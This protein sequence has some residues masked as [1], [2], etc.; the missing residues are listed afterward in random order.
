M[1]KL[2]RVL[3]VLIAIL[4]IA[5]MGFSGVVSFTGPNW[6]AEMANL[7]GYT[8][9]TIPGEKPTYQVVRLSDSQNVGSPV[10]VRA[11]ALAI[12]IKD[13]AEQAQVELDVLKNGQPN[14]IEILNVRAQSIR[15]KQY[16]DADALRRYDEDLD[17][18]L[19]GIRAELATVKDEQNRLL[20]EV[21]KVE[22]RTKSRREDVYRLDFQHRLVLAQI[23]ES[24][25]NIAAL[26]EQIILL[27]D[28]LDKALRRENQLHDQGVPPA[29]VAVT[30]T[31]VQ[32]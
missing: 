18:R 25:Q 19:E 8:F 29:P 12:A 11:E 30:S 20:A 21:D 4:S 22:R 3:V 10:G 17:V 13:K 2:S 15:D 31:T 23:E 27:E 6:K 9:T 1:Q 14:K 24:K 32:E 7:E 16:T 5:F 26:E 28:E